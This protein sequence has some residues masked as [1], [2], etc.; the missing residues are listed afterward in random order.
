MTVKDGDNPVGW[1][2]DG[3]QFPN[4]TLTAA[5]MWENKFD[6]AKLDIQV[7]RDL[8]VTVAP[9]KPMVGP[10]EAVELEITTVDQLGRPAAAELSIAMI[11]QSLL[12]LYGDRMPPIG[13]FFYNQTRT[14][15]FSTEATNTFHYAP[16]TV[17]VAQAVVDEAERAAAVAANAAGPA[18]QEQSEQV[19]VDTG[20]Q[21]A[22]GTAD[23]R[24]RAGARSAGS[25]LRPDRG[26]M[27]GGGW[28]E[29]Q[30]DGPENGS[31][32]PR[33]GDVGRRWRDVRQPTN[34]SS[35]TTRRPR[36]NQDGGRRQGR[37][38]KMLSVRVARPECARFS[39][40]EGKPD[41][42]ERFVETAYWNPGGDGQG[43]QGPGHIQGPLGSVRVPDH[44]PRRDRSRNARRPD[45]VVADRAQEL[46]RRSQDPRRAHPGRQAAAHRPGASPRRRR[47]R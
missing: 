2:I 20:G 17:P 8:R 36:T 44:G 34:G 45:D 47:A 14:G 31:L 46:L 30:Q 33:A 21:R 6:Q 11:D 19:K 29:W 40:K 7:E 27:G 10:G 35:G 25:G 12:R 39:A 3:P 43:R 9:V 22:A 42:R 32:V 18:I 37:S 23:C 26:M 24:L 16:A 41:S 4:F 38:A 13:G 28:A 5:R 15:A 1:A